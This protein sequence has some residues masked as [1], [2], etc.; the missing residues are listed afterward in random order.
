[1]SY[2]YGICYVPFFFEKPLVRSTFFKSFPKICSDY[3]SEKS[4]FG[5]DR[6]NPPWVWILSIHDPFLDLPKKTQNPFLD[7][8]IRIW[9]FPKNAPKLNPHMASRPGF[10]P[11]PHWWE[12]S[13]LTTAPSLASQNQNRLMV[14]D[15][16]E[17]FSSLKV[18]VNINFCID[19]CWPLCFGGF[20]GHSL[21]EKF[22]IFSYISRF[23]NCNFEIMGTSFSS[24]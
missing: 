22:K 19:W 9:I 23:W 2:M 17:S 11:W 4:G 21:A 12:A 14:D 5:I 18:K 6:K 8:E 20:L 7:S 3:E 16:W 15:Y 13:T 24:I 10:E 1:M